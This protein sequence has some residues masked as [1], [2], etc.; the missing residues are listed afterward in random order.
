MF[1]QHSS[2]GIHIHFV[3]H[4]AG[5]CCFYPT[6][7]AHTHTDGR[8]CIQHS[9]VV[10][11]LHLAWLLDLLC[12]FFIRAAPIARCVC[13]VFLICKIVGKWLWKCIQYSNSSSFQGN[14]LIKVITVLKAI[15]KLTMKQAINYTICWLRFSVYVFW[16]VLN[17]KL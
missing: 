10:C 8:T 12:V 7:C 14:I 17:I 9:G 13:C 2:N 5:S 1:S 6:S 11:G 15:Q 3:A 16:M 4:T